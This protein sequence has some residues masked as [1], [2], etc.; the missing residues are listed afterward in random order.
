MSNLVGRNANQIP[1]VGDLGNLAFQNANSLPKLVADE[2]RVDNLMTNNVMGEKPPAIDIDFVNAESARYPNSIQTRASTATYMGKDGYLKTAAV[3]EMRIE[4]DA[5]THEC[6]GL[7]MERAATNLMLYSQELTNSNWITTSNGSSVSNTTM[8]SPT[9]TNYAYK[10]VENINNSTHYVR[11]VFTKTSGVYHT[12]SVYAK[13]AERSVFQIILSGYANWEGYTVGGTTP[14]EAFF[15]LSSGTAL[16]FNP[17]GSAKIENCGNGWYRCSFTL[18]ALNST[19]SNFNLFLCTGMPE[20]YDGT[21]INTYTGDG[22]SGMYFWGAQVELYNV[23]TSYIKTTT[24]EATRAVDKYYV[25][26]T[27]LSPY[28]WTLFAEYSFPYVGGTSSG[29]AAEYNRQVATILNSSSEAS[30]RFG[31]IVS[32]NVTTGRMRFSGFFN[33]SSSSVFASITDDPILSSLETLIKNTVYKQAMSINPG[34][35]STYVDHRGRRALMTGATSANCVNPNYLRLGNSG[36][37]DDYTLNG[38][39]RKVRVYKVALTDNELL[40]MTT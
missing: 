23:A 37:F 1:L 13:A 5:I 17:Y 31:L 38:H 33:A 21:G 24:A 22:T 27:A 12:V 25:K 14:P 9:G 8:L 6:K 28:Q 16:T 3:D 2:L 11:Q 32:T 15:D 30:D 20:T 35:V 39:I 19:V 10:L 29:A 18:K 7:L 4:Y 26:G 36:A 40:E 34:G